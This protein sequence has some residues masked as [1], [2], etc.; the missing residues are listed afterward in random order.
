MLP[1]PAGV[2]HLA[3][4]NRWAPT[5]I[6]TGP[7]LGREDSTISRLVPERRAEFLERAEIETE[8]PSSQRGSVS[9]AKHW[10]GLVWIRPFCHINAKA[11]SSIDRAVNISKILRNLNC[12]RL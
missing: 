2:L 8:E 6:R 3:Y 4:H 12:Y 1:L 7:L 5:Q 9:L 11:N 10:G